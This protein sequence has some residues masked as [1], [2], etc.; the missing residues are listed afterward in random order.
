A[1]AV[2][3]ELRSRGTDVDIRWIG[4]HAGVER[5]IA[6]SQGIPFQAIQTGKLRRYVSPRT[7]IDAFR[8]PVGITQA[9]GHIRR[10]QPHVI[11]S[12]GGAVSVPTVI[13]GSRR[14]PILTH[15]QT[16]QIGIAN[17]ISARFA[18]VFAVTFHDTATLAQQIHKQVV[19]TGNPVRTSLTGGTKEGGYAHFGFSPELPVLYVTGGAR[20]ASP[21]NTRLE[22]V[23]ARLLAT[24]QIVHQVGPAS[25]NDDAARLRALRA[26]WPEETQRRYVVEEFVGSEIADLYAITDLVLGRAG[27][28]T[29]TELSFM[30]FPSVL[31]P[32]PGTWGDEQRKNAKILTGVGAAVT[33]EQEEATP[34]RLAQTLESLIGD[35]ARL[36][37]MSDA[38]RTRSQPDAASLLV[39]QLLQLAATARR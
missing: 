15:E 13:A 10:F 2:I 26:T 23:L 33:L 17:R 12:T 19:I 20:G 30:G 7:V 38:A 25:A 34:E 5:E 29:V 21:I 39:D 3:Q 16:A 6:E 35:P 18:D 1:V 27:A 9:W 24:M 36:Q 11:Y 8:V 37:S 14:A 4:S 32:L 22:P 28:G 31:I